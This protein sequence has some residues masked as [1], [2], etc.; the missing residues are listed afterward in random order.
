MGGSEKSIV[1]LTGGSAIA[2][3]L[4]TRKSFSHFFCP[5]NSLF[6][7]RRDLER[8]VEELSGELE[9]SIEP[10][11]IPALRQKVTDLTVYVSKRRE[12]VLSDTWDGYQEDRWKWNEQ[13]EEPTSSGAR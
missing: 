8:A 4:L 9:K 13:L 3:S 2:I 10:A 7:T 5:L 12:I 1:S 6:P 11:N